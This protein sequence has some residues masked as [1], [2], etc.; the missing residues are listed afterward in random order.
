MIEKIKAVNNPLTIIAIFAALAEVAGTVALKLMAENLQTV[1]IWYVMLF[2]VLLVIFFFTTLNFN[3]KVLYAPSD[4]KNEENFLSVIAGVN[5]ISVDLYDVQQQLELA[6]T[7]IIEDATK[8]ISVI[9][10]Q[11]RTRL[12]EV[13]N[14]RIKSVQQKI[15]TTRESAEN[16]AI[17]T[18]GP[19]RPGVDLKEEV[20]A[21][22]SKEKR[23]MTPEEIH[24]LLEESQIID[25]QYSIGH[26]RHLLH[27]L[28]G[29]YFEFQLSDGKA[30]YSL[31]E[32]AQPSDKS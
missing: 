21:I 1:F 15:E 7:H 29:R 31:A 30:K 4:F 23:P 26:L 24:K 13:V 11:E 14:N 8:Q 27:R 12:I 6:K 32:K 2:P 18:L 3:P 25:G 5:R 28:E 9:S 20:I 19:L 17:R 10:K 22:L 16:V